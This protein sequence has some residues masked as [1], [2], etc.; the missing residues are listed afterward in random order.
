MPV[1]AVFFCYFINV[2]IFNIYIL[3]QVVVIT[4]CSAKTGM[5]TLKMEIATYKVKLLAYTGFVF[6]WLVC[7]F[8]CN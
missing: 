2:L 6:S 5:G 3:V 4:V 8:I 1:S 7:A